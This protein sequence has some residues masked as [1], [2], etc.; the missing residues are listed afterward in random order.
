MKE[1]DHHLKKHVPEKT[2]PLLR[3]CDRQITYCVYVWLWVKRHLIYPVLPIN[4]DFFAIQS[5]D[6]YLLSEEYQDI[7]LEKILIKLRIQGKDILEGRHS[8][9]LH[10]I[11]DIEQF[12]P[13][14]LGKYPPGIGL[15]IIKSQ[16]ISRDSTPYYTS[17]S[18][19][20]ASTWFSMRAVGS[21]LEKMTVSNLLYLEGVAPRVYD[22]IELRSWNKIVFYAFVVQHIP[23]PVL[24]G[25]PAD[26][27]MTMFKSALSANG[28]STIS[29]KEHRDLRGPEYNRN[30]VQGRD[31]AY[32]VDIQNF[33]LA[34]KSTINKF[35]NAIEG[36]PFSSE[37]SRHV[38]ESLDREGAVLK[39]KNILAIGNHSS[40]VLPY[41]LSSGSS[42]CTSG[43]DQENGLV[44]FQRVL[45]LYGFSR[46]DLVTLGSGFN[47][48][49]SNSMR[50]SINIVLVD[51]SS[52]PRFEGIMCKLP[53]LESI[54]LFSNK[55]KTDLAVLQEIIERSTLAEKP[56]IKVLT[57]DTN[58]TPN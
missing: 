41:A 51:G 55:E 21:M 16:V 22:I 31:S 2:W 27:F 14:L 9:Y 35:K 38:A 47:Q 29:I 3:W 1:S 33:A 26:E 40:G 49:S 11:D 45:Y 46:F 53:S 23:G 52:L 50:S 10:E 48:I 30:I 42:W 39:D 12:C 6:S 25:K 58:S 7:T 24:T 43:L 5:I 8:V 36:Y 57:F 15:K 32:Y 37:K 4:S 44:E 13:T 28:M 34:E 56:Q 20:P 18:N 19:A 17:S 54:I